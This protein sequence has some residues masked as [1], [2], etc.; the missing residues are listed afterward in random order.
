MSDDLYRFPDP[1]V[2]ANI[3]AA[4][5]LDETLQRCVALLRDEVQR[6]DPDGSSYLWTMRYAR[7][8]EHLK[9]RLHGPPTLESRLREALVASAEQFLASLDGPAAAAAT[10][11]PKEQTIPPMDLEDEALE[12]HPDR[13]LLLTRYRRSQISLGGG[14]FLRDDRHVAIVTCALAQGCEATLSVLQTDAEGQVPFRVRQTALLKA[15][16]GALAAACWPPDKRV[17]YLAYHRNWLLRF[18]LS[19][20]RQG[21][22]RAEKLLAQYAQNVARMP[23]LQAIER[24]ANAQWSTDSAHG[25]GDDSAT[26]TP[27]DPWRR[28]IGD[29]VRYVPSLT[30]QPD[31]IVDPFAADPAFPSVFKV[32]HG[33]ANQ[34]G[35]TPLN[36]SFAHHLIL[37]VAGGG[38]AGFEIEPPTAPP[39]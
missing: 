10:A 12:A 37:H 29:L 9:V 15:V 38:D 14:V 39:S 27:G 33:L 26:Q 24:V 5:R 2:T 7:R 19:R 4:G 23:G 13:S 20:S 25:Q 34:L 18:L 28:T 8:G 21:A 30:D 1:L 3:Y 31:S 35:L 17:A 6:L 22:E 32:L 16:I 11:A 36:E